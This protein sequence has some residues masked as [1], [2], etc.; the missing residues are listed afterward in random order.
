MQLGYVGTRTFRSTLHRSAHGLAH[1]G[2]CS[3][4]DRFDCMNY[5]NTHEYNKNH[6]QIGTYL[7]GDAA[8]VKH[9]EVPVDCWTS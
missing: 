7:G 8:I 1:L 9:G 5:M 3:K 2:I 6:V 4:R